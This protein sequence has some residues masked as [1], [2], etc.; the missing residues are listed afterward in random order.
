MSAWRDFGCR[1]PF[2]ANAFVGRLSDFRRSVNFGRYPYATQ[3]TRRIQLK[4]GGSVMTVALKWRRLDPDTPRIMAMDAGRTLN[5]FALAI[6]H[7]DTNHRVCYDLFVEIQPRPNMPVSFNLARSVM[8]EIVHNMG[9]VVAVS[10]RWQNYSINDML[11]EQLGVT[12]LERRLT[13]GDFT[14]WRDDLVSG[15][16]EIPRPELPPSGLSRATSSEATWLMDKPTSTLL[17]QGIIV[18]DEPGKTV[19]K[20]TEGNDDVFRCAVLV[21]AASGMPEMREMLKPSDPASQLVGAIG[22]SQTTTR[23]VVQLANKLPETSTT[24]TI[25]VGNR[26]TGVMQGRWCHGQAHDGW[27]VNHVVWLQG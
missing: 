2:S 16:M 9:V 11:R 21:H 23:G 19:S 14:S 15:K 4:T 26:P 1:P 7:L 18:V 27:M 3:Q 24:E 25:V 6:A 13:Y 5:S 20:P 12:V 17:R 22:V 8:K 10:D